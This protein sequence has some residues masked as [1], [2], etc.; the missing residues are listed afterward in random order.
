MRPLGQ[1]A[2]TLL[3][4]VYLGAAL[5]VLQGLVGGGLPIH[6]GA[7]PTGEPFAVPA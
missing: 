1:T 2:T 6:V 3:V 7:L 4:L 5:A